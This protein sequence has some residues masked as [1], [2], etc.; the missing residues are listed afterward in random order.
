M[1][2]TSSF[3]I[4]SS[5]RCSISEG[6]DALGSLVSTLEMCSIM[7]P[8]EFGEREVE[9][10]ARELREAS[11]AGSTVRKQV[12]SPGKRSWGRVAAAL[13]IVNNATV[14]QKKAHPCV[15][16]AYHKIRKCPSLRTV[17]LLVCVPE[18]DRKMGFS[19]LATPAKQAPCER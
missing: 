19:I 11:S 13:E 12:V 1:A 3:P 14:G 9:P 8:G 16:Y 2:C 6:R 15:L 4:H 17:T 18:R 10:L 7:K 5:R